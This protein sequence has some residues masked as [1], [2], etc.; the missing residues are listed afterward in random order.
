MDEYYGE[1]RI[2]I[3]P[4]WD[5]IL[6]DSDY[7]ELYGNAERNID[8]IATQLRLKNGRYDVEDIDIDGT[9]IIKV[10]VE[11]LL[12]DGEVDFIDE[13]KPGEANKEG[14]FNLYKSMLPTEELKNNLNFDEFEI[15]VSEP[16]E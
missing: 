10:Y 11:Y 13:E 7:D 9:I 6:E 14:L 2:Y 5:I 16:E 12:D 4:N 3:N 1:Q 8:K 15:E